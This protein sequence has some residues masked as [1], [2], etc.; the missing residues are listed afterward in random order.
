IKP[1]YPRFP[2]VGLDY[3]VFSVKTAPY[4]AIL[5]HRYAI[6]SHTARFCYVVQ[7][8]TERFRF[9]VQNHTNA[10][11]V[12]FCAILYV[13]DML[14]RAILAASDSGWNAKMTSKVV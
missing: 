11:N 2:L 8:H 6:Q 3:V 1:V 7:R 13:S 10:P 4:R 5:T 14:Y 9:V 12:P